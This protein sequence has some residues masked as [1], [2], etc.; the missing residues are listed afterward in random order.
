MFFVS[1]RGMLS[2]IFCTC[3]SSSLQVQARVGKVLFRKENWIN[4]KR[5]FSA[6]TKLRFWRNS[7]LTSEVV[8]FRQQQ[9]WKDDPR[10]LMCV[11]LF[12]RGESS[13]VSKTEFFHSRTHTLET[14]SA[15]IF[16]YN[17]VTSASDL[18]IQHQSTLQV[19]DW[20][21]TESVYW[22]PRVVNGL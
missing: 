2:L 19:F 13:K 18:Q 17:L 5:M 4:Y 16:R 3:R 22:N 10:A 1:R 14:E 9:H 8:D 21:L 15:L 20:D 7:I 11:S 6:V 12:L